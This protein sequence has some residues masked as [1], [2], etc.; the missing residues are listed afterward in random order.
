VPEA[1]VS[2]IT[3]LAADF[4][5]ARYAPGA[6]TADIV[7]GA[8]SSVASPGVAMSTA[9]LLFNCQTITGTFGTASQKLRVNN[10]TVSPAWTVSIAATGGATSNWSSGPNQYDFKRFGRG[11]V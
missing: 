11:G 8:G 4:A 10:T 2:S 7:D 1:T 3:G 9:N 5:Y 6:L